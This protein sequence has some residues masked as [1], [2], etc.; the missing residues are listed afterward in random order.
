MNMYQ[1]RTYRNF[2][3]K[4]ALT[5]FNVVVKETDLFV[6]ALKPLEDITRELI[7]KH[8][9]YIEAYIK[10]YPEFV[11]ALKPWHVK[12]PAPIII[13]EMAA[14]GVM[15]GVGPMAAVAGAIAEH[16]GIDL[17]LHTEEVIV[18][19]GGD[20]FFK[21]SDPVT[22]GIYAG[23]SQLSMRIGLRIDSR[24]KPFSVCTSSGTIGHSLSLG[25]ADAVCVISD[26]CSLADAAATSICNKIKTKAHIQPAID[27]GKIIEGVNGIF[28]IMDDEIGLWGELEVVQLEREK[29]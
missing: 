14:A 9:G 12:G 6:H 20:I 11:Q 28:V 26:S 8:R 23:T 21:T 5:S 29:G 15:A 19:N 7:L 25:K 22:I 4:K 17:L 3:Q 16:V 18:E 2:L 27:F 10:R 1:N 13:N 24:E